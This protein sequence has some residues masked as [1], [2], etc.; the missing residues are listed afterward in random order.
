MTA[1]TSA[2]HAIADPRGQ[3]ILVLAALL[4]AFFVNLGGYALFDLDEGAFSEATREM[5]ANG[6]YGSTTVD[7]EPRYDKPIL[8]YW[9]QAVFVHLLGPD[10]LAFRLPSA[11]AALAWGLALWGFVRER[12]DTEGATS[13]AMVVAFGLGSGVIGRVATADGLLNLWL[14]LAFMDMVRWYEAPRRPVLWRTWLWLALGFLTKGPVAVGI[15]A[16]ASLLFFSS[17]GRWR[18][19]LRAIGTP[20]GWLIFLAVNVPWYVVVYLEQGAGFFR[21]FFLEHNLGRFTG[22][23]ESHGGSLGYYFVVLPIVLLPFTGWFL[24]TLPRLRRFRDLPDDERFGWTW[25]ALVFVLVSL[26]ATQLPHYILYGLTPLALVMARHRDALRSRILAFLPPLLLA[27][28]LLALPSLAAYGYAHIDAPDVHA[29]LARGPAAFGTGYYVA[30][31][32][33]VTAGLAVAFLPWP[34][35][36]RLLAIGAIQSLCLVA[37]VTP[38]LANLQQTPVREAALL[39]RESSGPVIAWGV[40][41]PSF[42]VYRRASTPHR[43]PRPG[44]TVFTRA[45][46]VDDLEARFPGRALDTLYRAGGIAL[47]RVPADS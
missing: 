35:V 41:K 16:V 18:D 33:A 6:Q 13:A 46:R 30:V 32:A 42:S 24:A 40:D 19:W 38:A 11:L 29:L 27:A 12:D 1:A 37:V 45:H 7:G 14:A 4:L 22:T 47:I 28:G 5:V 44:D 39:A 34:P 25:F 3:R 17:S 31:G 20:V 43:A 9:A 15:P 21:A 23:M 36:R 26:S 8:T 2:R 10:E